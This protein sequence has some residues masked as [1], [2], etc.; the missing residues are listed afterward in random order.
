MKWRSRGILNFIDWENYETCTWLNNEGE[1]GWV[2][3]PASFNMLNGFEGIYAGGVGLLTILSIVL[4]KGIDK[5]FIIKC[6]EKKEGPE[7]KKKKGK[8]HQQ[9][10]LG[11]LSMQAR[12]EC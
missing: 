3:V 9:K 11:S 6:Y 1:F 10:H 12:R 8:H 4:Q 7:K 5:N 2:S